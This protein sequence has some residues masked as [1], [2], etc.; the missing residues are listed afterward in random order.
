VVTGFEVD[1]V[2]GLLNL[3]EG[4]PFRLCATPFVL[5]LL[6][7]NAVFTALAEPA[8]ARHAIVPGEPFEP[9]DGS[10]MEILPI[11]VPAKER[12]EGTDQRAPRDDPTVGLIVTDRSTSKRIAYFP[13]CAAITDDLREHLDYIDVLFFDGTLFTDRELIEQ[14][15]L[16]KTGAMMGHIS[17]SGAEGAIESLRNVAIGRR[18]FIHLN[19]SNP[20]LR[21]DSR[22]R[23]HVAASGWDV[24]F[25]GMEIRL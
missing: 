15:L 12:S 11:S 22:E 8:V 10:Q 9:F 25:D 4:Q 3:R 17:M 18:V 21:N 20:V 2:A 14:M 16:G 5:G 13:C 7:N 24:A 6:T 23:S 19:N 1:Q